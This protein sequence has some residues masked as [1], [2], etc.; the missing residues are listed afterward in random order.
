MTRGLLDHCEKVLAGPYRAALNSHSSI[1][2][3]R[4]S[5]AM[6]S[7]KNHAPAAG[8]AG[9]LVHRNGL[10]ARMLSTPSLDI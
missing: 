5:T 6:M 10:F 1:S 4:R 3:S 2:N 8:T 9:K 7:I